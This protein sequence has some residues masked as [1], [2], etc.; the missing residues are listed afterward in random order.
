[1]AEW[2]EIAER[3][4]NLKWAEKSEMGGICRILDMYEMSYI[5][6]ELMR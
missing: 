5:E 4:E 1:M 3:A 2:A 6:H